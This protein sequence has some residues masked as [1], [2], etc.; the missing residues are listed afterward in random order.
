MTRQVLATFL[1]TALAAA[2][3][4]SGVYEAGIEVQF[5]DMR[6]AHVVKDLVRKL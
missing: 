1:F 2:Q 5:K 4:D 6:S 3:N